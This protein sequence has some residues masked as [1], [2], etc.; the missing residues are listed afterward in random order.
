MNKKAARNV[1][2]LSLA[3]VTFAAV[4]FGLYMVDQFI[5][6]GEATEL[7]G[8]VKYQAHLLGFPI[9]STKVIEDGYGVRDKMLKGNDTK[10]CI[11]PEPYLLI[12][13]SFTVVTNQT[14]VWL[15]ASIWLATAALATGG[16]V[17]IN[18]RRG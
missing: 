17:Y 8:D 6:R 10:H 4:F 3:I 7:C 9:V 11:I 16:V 2:L 15:N 1:P 18:K 13:E 5:H 12:G 14:K